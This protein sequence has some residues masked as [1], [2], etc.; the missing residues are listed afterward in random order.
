MP[1]GP[2]KRASARPCRRRSIRCWP[3]SAWD[4]FAC[5]GHCPSYRTLAAW[6]DARLAGNEFLFH[7]H[8]VGWRLDRAAFD[9]MLVTAVSSRVMALL[10][11]KVVA[12]GKQ[13]EGWRVSLSDGTAHMAHF[14]VDATGRA[15]AL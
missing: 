14:V 8:Q 4:E 3:I 11:A 10:R 2:V 13:T 6:G 1:R 5:G 12:L 7:A 9:R 15:A